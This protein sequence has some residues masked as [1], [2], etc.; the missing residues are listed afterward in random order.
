MLSR[1]WNAGKYYGLGRS[2]DFGITHCRSSLGVG[3]LEN[4]MVL[5]GATILESLIADPL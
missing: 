2:S 1:G 5:M 4:T 3:M